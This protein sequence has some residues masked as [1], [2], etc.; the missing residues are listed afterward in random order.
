LPSSFSPHGILQEDCLAP[1]MM[2][3]RVGFVRFS[4]E[5]WL[6]GNLLT[7]R[8][9]ATTTTPQDQHFGRG[10]SVLGPSQS[11]P[12]RHS[13]PKSAEPILEK[14]DQTSM[15]QVNDLITDFQKFHVS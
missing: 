9:S 4:P 12:S 13:K 10:D 7:E 5:F 3:K 1:E 2:W 11:S 14:Y 6:L 8:I 15:R